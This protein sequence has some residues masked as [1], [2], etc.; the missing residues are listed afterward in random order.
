MVRM[1]RLTDSFIWEDLP[2]T[3]PVTGSLTMAAWIPRIQRFTRSIII[4][5]ITFHVVQ[6]TIR[7][8]TSD[9]PS[10]VF[11]T[12]YPF[13][14]KKSPAFEVINLAQ[15]KCLYCPMLHIMWSEWN[16]TSQSAV[17]VANRMAWL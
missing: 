17:K 9:D 6:G 13:D 2:T 15:V 5:A 16:V 11:G 12:G 8:L 10:F 4:S 1:L 14:Q 3:D 7:V